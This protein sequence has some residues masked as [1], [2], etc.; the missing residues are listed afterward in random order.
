MTL[1]RRT[2][3]VFSGEKRLIHTIRGVG[4][5]LRESTGRHEAAFLFWGSPK[6]KKRQDGTAPTERYLDRK[7]AETLS[8]LCNE[9]LE[10]LIPSED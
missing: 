7:S 1:N 4:Y 10:L 8:D 9:D 3:E 2:R 5:A 6:I